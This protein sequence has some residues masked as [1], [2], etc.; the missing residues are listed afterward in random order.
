MAIATLDFFLRPEDGWVL[1][2]TNP[3][4]LLIKPSDFK[5]W[6]VAVTTGGAPADDLIGIQMGKDSYDR[7]EAFESGSITGEVYVRIMEPPASS[8]ASRFH[9]GVLRDQ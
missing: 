2:A 6:F 7:D 5:P 8:P 4:S 9:F 1:F 3:T